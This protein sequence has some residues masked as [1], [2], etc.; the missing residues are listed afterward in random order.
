MRSKAWILLGTMTIY[1]ISAAIV[2][3]IRKVPILNKIVP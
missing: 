2:M 1:V 3:I